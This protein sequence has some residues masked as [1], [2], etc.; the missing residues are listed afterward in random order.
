MHLVFVLEKRKAVLI[1]AGNEVFPVKIL[2]FVCLTYDKKLL[3][4]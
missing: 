1:E 2:N 3:K 4:I